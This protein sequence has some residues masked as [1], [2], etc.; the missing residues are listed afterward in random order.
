[1]SPGE[2][3]YA[4]GEGIVATVVFIFVVNAII[5]RE[6]PWWWDKAPAAVRKF[7]GESE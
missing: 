3:L 1:M 7:F 2:L 4:L 5:P 6:R